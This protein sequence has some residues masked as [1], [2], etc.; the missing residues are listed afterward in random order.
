MLLYIATFGEFGSNSTTDGTSA[1]FTFSIGATGFL[2]MSYHG[3][4]AERRNSLD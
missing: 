3:Q 4:I 1:I 2:S